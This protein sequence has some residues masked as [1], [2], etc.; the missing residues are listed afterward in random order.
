MRIANLVRLLLDDDVS[1]LVKN[2]FDG[3]EVLLVV[4]MVATSEVK[5]LWCMGAWRRGAPDLLVSR[6][7]RSDPERP[8]GFHQREVGPVALRPARFSS[9]SSLG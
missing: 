8:G 3:G 7:G 1:I 2:P 5:P 9:T 6:K 4:Y